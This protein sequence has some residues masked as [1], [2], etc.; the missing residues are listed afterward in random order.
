MQMAVAWGRERMPLE[1]IE[2]IGVDEIAWQSGHNYLTLV[3]Q[4]DQGCRRLLWVGR[5]RRI[6]TL[7]E[8]FDWF[9]KSRSARLRVVC[10]DMWKAYLRVVAER[11]RG[12]CTCWT[13]STSS[14]S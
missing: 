12:R 11:A 9:G 13:A 14:R 2:T 6:A 7:E 1:G 3:Y 5:E 10:S 4:L 8:F